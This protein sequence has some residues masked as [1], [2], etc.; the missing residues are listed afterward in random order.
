M[1]DGLEES[2]DVVV[3]EEVERDVDGEDILDSEELWCRM[4]DELDGMGGRI[5]DVGISREGVDMGMDV[6]WLD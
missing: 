5:V 4:V 1:G 3:D 2:G 6:G